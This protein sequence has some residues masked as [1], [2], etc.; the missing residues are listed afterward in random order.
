MFVGGLS[1]HT[2]DQDLRARFSI[3]G[4]IVECKVCPFRASFYPSF[5]GRD[6]AFDNGTDSVGPCMLPSTYLLVRGR[7]WISSEYENAAQFLR[8]T[9]SESHHGAFFA[10][11]STFNSLS[12]SHT[13]SLTSP[14]VSLL[15]SLRLLA[16][17]VCEKE[18]QKSKGYGFVTFRNEQSVED[19]IREANETV[20]QDRPIRVH[21]ADRTLKYQSGTAEGSRTSSS[22]TKPD[23]K[24]NEC[25][26]FMK[27][28]CTRGNACRFV[29]ATET[30][31]GPADSSHGA[32]GGGYRAKYNGG[33]YDLREARHGQ[34]NSGAHS[35]SRDTYPPSREAVGHSGAHSSSRDAYHPLREAEG[36][37]SDRRSFYTTAPSQDSYRAGSGREYGDEAFYPRDPRA[38][39]YSDVRELR[40]LDARTADY[41]TRDYAPP[42]ARGGHATPYG[43]RDPYQRETDGYDPRDPRA[44]EQYAAPP[45]RDAAY[46]T[47]DDAY[48][49]RY[50]GGRGRQLDPA[51]A[52]ARPDRPPAQGRS[53]VY[54]RGDYYSAVSPVPAQREGAY[55]RDEG[56][57]GAYIERDSARSYG[58]AEPFPPSREVLVEPRRSDPRRDYPAERDPDGFGRDS[59]HGSVGGYGPERREAPRAAPAPYGRGPL[60]SRDD[61][62]WDAYER[63]NGN[64]A[65]RGWERR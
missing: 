34:Y 24:S 61:R 44:R 33:E 28:R 64:R 15:T 39:E 53:V 1:Y 16:K 45:P 43:G 22:E 13:V 55:P 35:S 56:R 46:P 58:R 25:F 50:D 65:D 11:S 9:M 10:S 31:A 48:D 42:G 12:L 7:C 37:Y 49:A 2:T 60:P 8:E 3:F 20:L 63:G 36:G 19:A 40:A 41:G 57:E 4:D 59:Y 6:A 30:E 54:G 14:S 17:V 62:G 23:G 47:R 21:H 38:R 26:D 32:S 51:L 29:H 5:D 52:Y 18:T 27:G